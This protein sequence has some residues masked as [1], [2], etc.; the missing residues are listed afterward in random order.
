MGKKPRN[1]KELKWRDKERITDISPDDVEAGEA[2]PGLVNG[3]LGQ[4][5]DVDQFEKNR[6]LNPDD[7]E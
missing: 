2:L 7:F 3:T 1:K 5:K 4:V 6:D